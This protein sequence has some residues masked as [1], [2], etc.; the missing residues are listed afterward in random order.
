M[1]IKVSFIRIKTG[2]TLNVHQK[3]NL[4]K[5]CHFNT[6]ENYL[7]V[8]KNIRNSSL[9]QPTNDTCYPPALWNLM[10][11]AMPPLTR[12]PCP[13]PTVKSACQRWSPELLVRAHWKL[14]WGYT[15]S[16]QNNTAKFQWPLRPPVTHIP[17]SPW[18]RKEQTV[19]K[20]HTYINKRLG[21]GRKK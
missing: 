13:P 14:P 11:G 16:V 21:R 18:R 15:T 6:K 20:R 12:A 19:Y 5:L 10:P 17:R 2:N 3:G 9:G 4:N 8:I 1:F 7:V